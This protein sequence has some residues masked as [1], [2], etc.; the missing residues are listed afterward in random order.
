MK[1][2]VCAHRRHDDLGA[3]L[4]PY[5][6]LHRHVA[7]PVGRVARGDKQLGRHDSSGEELAH[8][9]TVCRHEHAASEAAQ[10]R[11]WDADRPRADNIAVLVALLNPDKEEI[12]H[13]IRN[14]RVDGAVVEG[15]DEVPQRE[16]VHVAAVVQ[17][18]QLLVRRSVDSHRPHLGHGVEDFP[19]VVLRGLR[20]PPLGVQVAQRG[21]YLWVLDVGYR[22]GDETRVGLGQVARADQLQHDA[23]EP[24]V[25]PRLLRTVD[26]R[27]VGRLSACLASHAR[28]ARL[29]VTQSVHHRPLRLCLCHG[30]AHARS[31]LD[32]GRNQLR[33][34]LRLCRLGRRL[35]DHRLPQVL[36][37]ALH[38]H[39]DTAK[40]LHGA[41]RRVANEP[42]CCDGLSDGD[43]LEAPRHVCRIFAAEAFLR[44][45]S[46][47]R[48]E[49]AE[50]ASVVVVQPL[51]VVLVAEL[52]R[53]LA[54]D[55]SPRARIHA[56]AEELPRDRR[57]RARWCHPLRRARGHSSAVRFEPL[58]NL[59]LPLV[60]VVEDEVKE[61]SWCA[62]PCSPTEPPQPAA[63]PAIVLGETPGLVIRVTVGQVRLH[64]ALLTDNGEEMAARTHLAR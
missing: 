15:A 42:P 41:E 54:L 57:P 13:E 8:A 38:Y 25:P 9:L 61:V 20:P 58:G 5:A 51:E 56:A 35:V 22:A 21:A 49:L 1:A 3:A 32:L 40:D 43:K 29:R 47:D 50:H 27:A 18:L 44:H 28:R 60:V 17:R 10:R 16:A 2:K 6:N 36:E 19:H 33:A 45:A 12:A 23:Q 7:L 46:T 52:R 30:G 14:R 63:P 4:D 31:L 62:N 59:I 53:R 39:T 26:P 55:E 48:V 37:V 11:G 24:L 34:Q 64:R